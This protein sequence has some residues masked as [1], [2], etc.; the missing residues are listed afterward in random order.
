MK[1]VLFSTFALAI[2]FMVSCKPDP[3]IDEDRTASIEINFVAEYQNSPVVSFSE[4]Y[5]YPE[6]GNTFNVKTFQFLITDLVLLKEGTGDATELEEVDLIVFSDK[7]T[8]E[9]A[10]KGT[11][12]SYESI[13]VG[14]YSG[15]RFGLGVNNELNRA[16][17]IEDYS[18]NDPLGQD[19]WPGWNSYVFSKLEGDFDMNGDGLYDDSLDISYSLHTGTNE[20]YN[21]IT[22]NAPITVEVGSDNVTKVVV[23]LEK[24]LVGAEGEVYD[25]IETPTTH[26]LESI[27]QVLQLLDNS[28]N[29]FSIR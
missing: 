3:I 6:L 14:E 13:P 19:F 7:M 11:A 18:S 20:G 26:S 9:S 4:D 25:I 22:I 28:K 23:D 5:S 21:V 2:L 12:R 8:E 16:E 27:D 1:K 10:I 24:M 29:A 17:T 15:I